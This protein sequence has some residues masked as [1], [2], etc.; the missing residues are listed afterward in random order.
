M[1][2]NEQSAY[3]INLIPLITIKYINVVILVELFLLLPVDSP[4]PCEIHDL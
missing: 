3:T 4:L 1:Q 2:L